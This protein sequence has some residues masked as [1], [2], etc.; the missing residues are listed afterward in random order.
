MG[1]SDNYESLLECIYHW[2]K[3]DPN[4]LYMTQPLGEGENDFK[5]WTWGEAVE[6][7]AEE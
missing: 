3:S 7:A 5:C 2:E 1:S 6:E 4:R